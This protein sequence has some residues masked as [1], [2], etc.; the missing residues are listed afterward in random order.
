MKVAVLISFEV[1]CNVC[2]QELQQKREAK[3]LENQRVAEE[4]ISFLQASGKVSK[5][6][7]NKLNVNKKNKAKGE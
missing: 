2:W 5:T 6:P 3:R 4:E 7:A 1:N